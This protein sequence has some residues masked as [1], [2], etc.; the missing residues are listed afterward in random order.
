MPNIARRLLE[1][2]LAFRVPDQVGDLRQQME[3][4]T[5]DAAKKARVVRF[6]HTHSHADQ[7]SEPEHDLSI[8]SETPFILADVLG[9]IRA[10]DHSHFDAMTAII[11]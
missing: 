6:L 7:V 10:N 3:A 2:F 1:S 5:F 9:L 8:L 11:S 4:M